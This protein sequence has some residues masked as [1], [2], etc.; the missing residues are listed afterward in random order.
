MSLE[1]LIEKDPELGRFIQQQQEV[2]R[3]KAVVNKLAEDCWSLCVSSPS[4]S[5]LD[6]K[7]ESCLNNCVDRFVD[8]SAYLVQNF[9]SKGSGASSS[10][11]DFG[12][13]SSSGDVMLDD[14]SFGSQS[15]KSAEP[16]AKQKS[17]FKFW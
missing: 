17:G 9:S 5:K 16:E 13:F 15:A 10:G 7:T 1:S 6:S 11:S 14:S 8:A 4:L 2:A 3:F 12:S